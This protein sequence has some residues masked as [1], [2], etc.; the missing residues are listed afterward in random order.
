MLAY[1]LLMVIIAL[2][3]GLVSFAASCNVKYFLVTL[4]GQY[5]SS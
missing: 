1:K 2:H 5:W 4:Y 3:F